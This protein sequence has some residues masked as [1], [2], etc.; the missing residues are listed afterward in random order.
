MAFSHT[1]TIMEDFV[2]GALKIPNLAMIMASQCGD[3]T[4]MKRLNI[5]NLTKSTTNTMILDADETYEKLSTNVTGLDSL[6]DRFMLALS[7]VTRI[8]ETLLFGRAASGLHSNGGENDVR[9]FYDAV[10]Q[11]QESKLKSQ[12]EKLIRYIMISKDGVFNGVEPDDWSVQFVP[13]WQNTEEQEAILRKLVAETDAIYID[14]AV[15]DPV[16]VAQSRFGGNKWSMNT[17]LDENRRMEQNPQE[18]AEIGNRKKEDMAAAIERIAWQ[19]VGLLPEKLEATG[20]AQLA[21]ILGICVD[22]MRLLREQATQ[23]K[24]EK[25][26]TDDERYAQLCALAERIRQRRLAESLAGRA[27]PA[28]TAGRQQIT[29]VSPTGSADAGVLQ[30]GG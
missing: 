10:K 16:E 17:E 25:E 18:V 24:Q 12:L 7:A 23:I 20:A 29:L 11:A 21:T 26:L 1:A 9:N 5:L 15:L 14:R 2:N 8:P 3:N 19:V 6:I 4:V 22:K 13:L 28:G 27:N 30:P